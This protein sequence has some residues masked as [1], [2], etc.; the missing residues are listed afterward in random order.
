MSCPDETLDPHMK[1]SDP[2]PLE[3]SGPSHQS[4]W[5]GSGPGDSC[6][7]GAVWVNSI[8]RV[9]GI[10][11]GWGKTVPNNVRPRVAWT[12]VVLAARAPLGLPGRSVNSARS[13]RLRS[14]QQQAPA[15]MGGS[16]IERCWK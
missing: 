4:P 3:G 11:Y 6:F 2:T 15:E 10:V 8:L 14:S 1:G 9:Y 16:R 12:L 13:T 5:F 7:H